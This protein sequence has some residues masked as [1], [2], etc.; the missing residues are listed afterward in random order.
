MASYHNLSDNELLSLIREDNALAYAEIYERYKFILHAHAL[1]KTRDR[2]EA[3]DVV[4]EVF[5]YLWD[6]RATIRIDGEV[7]GYLYTAM[8]NAFLNR[9]SRQIV[10]NKYT[11]SLKLFSQR[12]T[13][14]TDYRVRERQL[15]ELIEK[16]IALLPPKMR[17]VFELS[18]KQN[19]SHKE[20][21][22]L[23]DISEQTVS[24]QVTNALRILRVKLGIFVYL[25]FLLQ[26]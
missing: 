19:F 3:R 18:R 4:Q 12:D 13:V 17:E 15:K 14:E 7:S 10:K 20:I 11:E 24:K 22:E 1:N 9:V 23:L 8:R 16:E 6:K 5:V 21:S 26:R 2:E 25:Y